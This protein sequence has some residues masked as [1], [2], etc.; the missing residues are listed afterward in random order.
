MTKIAGSGSE[1]ESVSCTV[2]YGTVR[3]GT[4]R[5]GTVRYAIIRYGSEIR[6]AFARLKA[7]SYNAVWRIRDVYP[8]S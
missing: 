1:S 7:A 2:R 5:L 6:N 4:A 3:Y 8:G